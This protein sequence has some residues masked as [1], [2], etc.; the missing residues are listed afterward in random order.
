MCS[1]KPLSQFSQMI[2]YKDGQGKRLLVDIET[3][4]AIA[5]LTELNM[6][7]GSVEELYSGS[8][9]KKGHHCNQMWH[10]LVCGSEREKRQAALRI[11]IAAS[12]AATSS[13]PI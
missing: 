2:A 3:Y 12:L 4:P 9:W 7:S 1:Q 6:D 8:C 13:E 10:T 5:Q 11:A